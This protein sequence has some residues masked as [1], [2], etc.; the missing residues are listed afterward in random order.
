MVSLFQSTIWPYRLPKRRIC[1]SRCLNT[2][3]L[4]STRQGKF[5]CSP[6][7]VPRYFRTLTDTFKSLWPPGIRIRRRY[8]RKMEHF[9]PGLQ[10]FRNRRASTL[11]PGHALFYR[12]RLRHH[13]RVLFG[14][15]Y[16][17]FWRP[18]SLCVTAAR[19]RLPDRH[20]VPRHLDSCSHHGTRRWSYLAKC[21]RWLV[22]C[23][24]LW[25]CYV[26]SGVSD[27]PVFKDDLY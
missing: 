7:L 1:L 14:G 18:P 24:D 19:D 23:E 11:D 9:H 13:V 10:Y 8:N 2:W 16:R 25:R 17:S 5:R 3:C 4:S 20:H 6:S 26:P 15:L 12:N 21:G 27:Y 22:G